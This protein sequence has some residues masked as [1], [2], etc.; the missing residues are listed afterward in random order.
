[1]GRS[2]LMVSIWYKFILVIKFANRGPMWEFLYYGIKNFPRYASSLSFS[3]NEWD[4]KKGGILYNSA[5]KGIWDGGSWS[6]RGGDAVPRTVILVNA[7]ATPNDLK[8]EPGVESKVC[9]VSTPTERLQH[10]RKLEITKQMVVKAKANHVYLPSLLGLGWFVILINAKGS[11]SS[12]K[13]I[14]TTFQIWPLFVKINLIQNKLSRCPYSVIKG[15]VVFGPD[16]TD[17]DLISPFLLRLSCSFDM[18]AQLCVFL[19]SWSFIRFWPFFDQWWPFWI[20][21]K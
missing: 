21:K 13:S 6:T 10:E 9:I 14:V 4:N 15:E 3:A 12:N 8:F 11:N 19:S 20:W 1:M 17:L 16:E 7:N 18:M 5:V 2:L